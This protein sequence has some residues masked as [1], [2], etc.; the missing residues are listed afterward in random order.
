MYQRILILNWR[1]IKTPSSGGAEI[2]THEMAKRWVS[3]GYP[4]TQ[5]SSYFPGAKKEEIIDGVKIIREGN[6]DARYL[7]N[8]VHI[9]AF[10][11][12]LKNRKEFDIVIDEIHGLPFFTPFYV[13]K[14]KVALICEVAGEIWDKNFSFPFNKIGK[15]IENNYF[16]F[17]KDVGF[18]TISESTKI[19][20]IKFGIR[21]TNI[22]VLPMGINVPKGLDLH[23]KEKNPTLIFVARLVKAKGVEDALW[24]CKNL[25]INNPSIKLWIIGR[26]DA[27]Y[28]KELK[29]LSRKMK[30]EDRVRFWGFVSEK[31]KF[32]L[33]SKAH[34]LLVP[35]VKEGFG[36]TV[37]EAGIVGT[38]SVAYNVEGLKDIVKSMQDGILVD[39]DINQMTKAIDKLLLDK[40]L[41]KKIQK[42][43]KES[44]SRLN[45]ENTAR[46]GIGKL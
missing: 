27:E 31:K 26:G 16:K 14:K 32:E 5:F 9:K 12:Y 37:P 2:L 17:Y 3:W 44:A 18:L 10:F 23:E 25:C 35:S 20:L 19:D 7:F 45:W 28:E 15:F 43:A 36:L 1:D 4:V 40:N 22:K 34:I 11:Y 42:N 8:S 38:P 33:L 39:V 29:S 6:P 46:A 41:Y 13:G 30:I 21:S 24:V